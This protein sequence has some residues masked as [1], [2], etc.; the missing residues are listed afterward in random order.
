VEQINAIQR[1]SQNQPVPVHLHRCDRVETAQLVRP[2]GYLEAV[3]SVE[4]AR[5]M[6]E[7]PVAGLSG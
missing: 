5:D 7:R 1:S 4:R 3:A 6:V 2:D